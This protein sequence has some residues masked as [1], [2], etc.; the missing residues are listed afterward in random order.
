LPNDKLPFWSIPPE[1]L[2]RSFN[3]SENG[4]TEEEALLRL[5]EYGPNSLKS[6][7]QPSGISLFLR[8]FKSPITLILLAA[9]SL[10]LSLKQHTDALIIL[11]I[12]IASGLLSF[13]NE[14]KSSVAIQKLLDI[15]RVK[16]RVIRSNTARD[17]P[18][19]EIVPGDIISLEAGDVIPGDCILM[20]SKDLFVNESSLTGESYPAEKSPG[21]TDAGRP[22]NKQTNT[23]F[24]GSHVY[25]G[26]AKAMVAHTGRSTVFGKL[27]QSV[28]SRS[29][30][31]N[32]ETGIRNFGYLLL[33]ITLILVIL[34][35]AFNVYFHRPVLEAFLFSLA[36]AVGLTPQLLPAIISVNLSHGARE[37]CKKQVIVRRLAAIENFG[38]MNVLC[39]DK[40]G[41]ITEGVVNLHAVVDYNGMES[42]KTF[43]YAYINAM[44]QGGFVNPID[45]AIRK[46]GHFDISEYRKL[47]EVPYDF[48]RKRLSILTEHPSGNIMICKGAFNNILEIC[49][50][51]ETGPNAITDLD[52]KDRETL[53]RR[54]N[55]LSSQGYRVLGIAYK[56]MT[57]PVISKEQERELIFLGFLVLND[58]PKKDIQE[59]LEKLKVLG[60]SFKV[61]TGDNGVVAASVCRQIGLENTRMLTGSELNSITNEALPEKAKNIDV[62]AEI[63]PAQKEHIIHALRRSGLVV[64]YLGDGINDAPALHA[65]DVSISVEGAAEVAKDA[66]D[67]VLLEKD[68]QVLIAGVEEGRRTF[69]NT[70]KYI[71][72]AASANFG[73]M[74][75]V[76]G[77][78]LFLPF[79]P[80]L[81]KQILLLNLMTDFPELAIASDNVDKEMVRYPRHWDI[82]LI[83]KFMVLFGLISSVFDYITF[84]VLL[85][86]LHAGKD[87]FRTGWFI[88]S[89]ISASLIVLVIRTRKPFLQSRPGKYLAAVTLTIVLASLAIPFTPLKNL[90]DFTAL[91]AIFYLALTIIVACYILTAEI[92]KHFFFGRSK[93]RPGSK[94]E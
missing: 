50:R 88:E 91:P 9:A 61:I 32:F 56:A 37:M 1:E 77:A 18:V 74:F 3:S 79:L 70:L 94:V 46:A 87:Q 44:R 75:S 40:T 68:L 92:A 81:P 29:T 64:G 33:E 55:D 49:R 58:P 31:T 16:V 28:K 52:D 15:I 63:E 20:Q 19:E 78:S 43:L 65:A 84:F 5:K 14:R 89:I 24:M 82:R 90:F 22:L 21:V 30:E 83:R 35:F 25:S 2:L 41:T 59:T 27:A 13:W 8:Q 66:A 45:E 71:F 17:I 7:G 69:T 39:S 76:A 48:S 53:R 36:I 10:S 93:V 26:E 6:A 42:E 86:I 72:M 85:K 12:V 38:S 60:I 80:L 23:L 62:F 57:V 73:N 67:I 54:F 11:V 34:I 47:D 51:L 4:L